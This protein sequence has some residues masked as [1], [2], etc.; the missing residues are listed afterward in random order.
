M[1]IAF[2][3]FAIKSLAVTA[4]FSD[5]DAQTIAEYS[6]MVDDF[7]FTAYWNCTNVPDYIKNNSKYDLCV[8]LGLFNP[9]QTGFLCG[10][11]LGYTDYVNLVIERFQ[12]FTCA[13]FHFIYEERAQI[14]TKEYRVSPATLGNG[15]IISNMLLEA[16]NDY[17]ASAYGTPERSK[18]L[19]KI[20]MLLHIFADTAA[21]QMFSGF[22]ANVNQVSLV[23]VTNNITNVD[24]TEKYNDFVVKFLKLL[25]EWMPAITPA[26]GHMMLEHIP[27][28]THIS[29]TMKY[30]G[31][32]RAERFY[33]RSNTSEFI[34][35]SKEILN[36]L[37]ACLGSGEIPE[38]RW[39]DLRE[40][41][42]KAFLTD[43]SGDSDESSKVKHLQ[44][45]WNVPH[46]T[47]SYNSAEIKKGF[48]KGAAPL[49]APLNVDG[50]PAELL[51]VSS[52]KAS[53]D[54]YTF[55]VIAD[56]VLI[57]LYG[58]HPRRL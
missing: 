30:T 35:M 28:L 23:N 50:I 40:L 19:M 32:D 1:D 20:G 29:F 9:T 3:Y 49:S 41:L 12:R 45:V 56:E 26:I 53:A 31:P 16:K 39:A 47:Y 54:F 11:L 55:N 48:E 15:S 10:G 38:N 17:R 44:K 42:R 36:Y 58:D 18:A 52:T 13:P 24:E 22:N 25:Q 21:H 2:H 34:K 4:G 51:P 46:C 43:I 14:G 7:D 6:Q 27:D 5:E 37:L 33:N 8:A 57:A